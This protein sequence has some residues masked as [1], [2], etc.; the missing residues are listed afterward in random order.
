MA[1]S[2]YPRFPSFVEAQN[3]S[4]MVQHLQRNT[5]TTGEYTA[6]DR[7]RRGYIRP[8]SSRG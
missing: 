4:V 5:Y 8:R 2:L 3:T 6:G 1:A 7:G